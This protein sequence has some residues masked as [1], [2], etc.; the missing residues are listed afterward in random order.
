M[1]VDRFNRADPVGNHFDQRLDLHKRRGEIGRDCPV[2]LHT[3]VANSVFHY[4][5]ETHI[6][7]LHFRSV[8]FEFLV[9]D[10]SQYGDVLHRKQHYFLSGV[11]CNQHI[12]SPGNQRGIVQTD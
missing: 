2:W 5:V 8:P 1:D 12:C 6:Q 3:A 9:A 11:S 4:A 7:F 10:F